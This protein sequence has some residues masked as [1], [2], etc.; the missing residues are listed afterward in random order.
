M[1]IALNN[2]IR[3]WGGRLRNGQ[4]GSFINWWFGELAQTLPAAWRA[5]MQHALRR[6]TLM[7]AAGQLKLGIEENRTTRWLEPFSVDQEAGLQKQAIRNLLEQQ[8]VKAAPKFLLLDSGKVLRKRLSLPAAAEPNLHQVL[9]F[10]MDRQTPFRA[11][12]VYFTWQLLGADKGNAQ[13]E[14]D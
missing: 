9:A 1:A 10:E 12:D 8:D 7:I 6:V 11:A 3:Y 5:R 13:I 4:V 2:K 14:I